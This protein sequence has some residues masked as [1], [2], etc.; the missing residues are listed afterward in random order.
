MLGDYKRKFTRIVLTTPP[1]LQ[2]KEKTSR[3]EKI[4][5]TREVAEHTKVAKQKKMTKRI[6]D[7][8]KHFV[9]HECEYIIEGH[10][11]TVTAK[12]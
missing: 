6:M 11:D 1:T 8:R 2:K 3:L 10:L 9:A 7:T 5:A 4:H 12:F